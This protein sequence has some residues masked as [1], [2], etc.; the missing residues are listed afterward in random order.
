M[1]RF[2]EFVSN[3]PLLWSLLAALTVAWVVVELR[4]RARG[5]VHL[6]TFDFTREL[7]SGSA[8]LIDLRP[9]CRI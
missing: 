6:G 4:S 2:M 8:L 5:S 1:Q 7:N 3:H 9:R